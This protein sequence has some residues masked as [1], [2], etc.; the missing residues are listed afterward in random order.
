MQIGVRELAVLLNVR[1][2]LLTFYRVPRD[3]VISPQSL[4]PG[5]VHLG[6]QVSIS[7]KVP[8]VLEEKTE[9]STEQQWWLC[10]NSIL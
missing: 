5:T 1:S 9:K 10:K 6:L 2:V 3:T 7:E 8:P 4:T